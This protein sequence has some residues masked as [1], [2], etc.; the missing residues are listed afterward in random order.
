MQICLLCTALLISGS[1]WFAPVA[2]QATAGSLY[3]AL[4]GLMVM[5]EQRHV[6]RPAGSLA[7]IGFGARVVRTGHGHPDSRG[8]A[9][10]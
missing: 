1:A 6:F 2:N 5:L 10:A 7:L 9:T 8:D 4:S 3:A